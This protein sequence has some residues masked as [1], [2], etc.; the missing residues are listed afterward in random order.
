V[1]NRRGRLTKGVRLVTTLR[2]RPWLILL[3]AIVAFWTIWLIGYGIFS[4][5]G[6]A[7]PAM[8]TARRSSPKGRSLCA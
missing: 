1:Q 4:L 3:V 6:D 7:P 2:T 5:G 8:G